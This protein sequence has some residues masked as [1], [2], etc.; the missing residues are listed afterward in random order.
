MIGNPPWDRI[1]LQEVEW[2]ATRDSELAL[3]PTA[4]ARKAGIRRLRQQGAPLAAEFDE[5]KSRADG[6]RQF[7]PQVRRLPA[8]RR[9]GP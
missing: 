2:F 7:D 5:A 1:K 8:A 4:A 9:R 3:A 6:A